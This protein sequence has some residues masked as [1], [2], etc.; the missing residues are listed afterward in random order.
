MLSNKIQI[1]RWLIVLI[2]V[3]LMASYKCVNFEI[4]IIVSTKIRTY[5]PKC[6]SLFQVLSSE[7]VLFLAHP[8][9]N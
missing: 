5:K 9:V 6:V 7:L 8:Q 2:T 3:F 4:K 1:N